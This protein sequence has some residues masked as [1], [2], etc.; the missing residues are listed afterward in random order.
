MTNKAHDIAMK[1][2]NWALRERAFTLE[3]ARR[4]SGPTSDVSDGPWLMDSEDIGVLVGTMGRFPTFRA[5]GWR[6]LESAGF[7]S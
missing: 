5:T 4:R 7:V 3:H 2:D 6:I 1:L